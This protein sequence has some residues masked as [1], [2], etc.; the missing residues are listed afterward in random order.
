MAMATQQSTVNFIL[1]QLSGAGAVSAKKMFGEFGLFLSGRMIGL[2]CDDRLFF[3]PT[4]PG[5]LCFKTLT[6]GVPYPGAKPCL[7]VPEEAWDDADWLVEV[8]LATVSAV[9]LPR[10][11]AK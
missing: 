11:K 7:L 10:K 4:A 8:A 1:D 9:P 2:I 5:R 6:E 3:K